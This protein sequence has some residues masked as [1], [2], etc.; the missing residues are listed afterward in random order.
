LSSDPDQVFGGVQFDAGEIWRNT[1]VAPSIQAGI[2][3]DAFTLC[4]AAGL[5]YIFRGM[6]GRW[7]PYAGGEL[8][9]IYI[10]VDRDLGPNQFGGDD[11]FEDTELGLSAAGG[12]QTRLAS[13]SLLNFEL[14]IG[15]I[16]AQDVQFHV[17]WL[18]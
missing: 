18:F 1:R 14:R 9:F 5:H 13:G 17:G 8:G 12:M 4:G 3:D 15:F 10:N 16:D 11:D 2:G 7:Q 6:G